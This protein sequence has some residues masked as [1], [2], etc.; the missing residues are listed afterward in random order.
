M[1]QV[2]R[3]SKF[4]FKPTGIFLSAVLETISLASDVFLPQLANYLESK[5]SLAKEYL[6]LSKPLL[7]GS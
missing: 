6:K 4:V 7:L 5:I 3:R 1:K 2:W